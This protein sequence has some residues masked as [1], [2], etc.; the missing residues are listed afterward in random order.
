[1]GVASLSRRGLSGDWMIRGR[2]LE[3]TWQLSTNQNLGS[4]TPTISLLQRQSHVINVVASETITAVWRAVNVYRRLGEQIIQFTSL[5]ARDNSVSSVVERVQILFT[6]VKIFRYCR[7]KTVMNHSVKL[8][9]NKS[10]ITR[11]D[12]RFRVVCYRLTVWLVEKRSVEFPT[13]CLSVARSGSRT[14]P[15]DGLAQGTRIRH[16][17]VPP[18]HTVARLGCEHRAVTARA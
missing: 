9:N 3:V 15:R 12:V 11:W 8:R 18:V 14:A 7:K 10:Y 13:D 5:C 4:R 16:L 1:M 6:S 17:R 2:G